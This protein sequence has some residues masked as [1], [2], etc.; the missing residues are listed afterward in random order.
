MYRLTKLWFAFSDLLAWAL[1]AFSL[2]GAIVFPFVGPIYARMAQQSITTFTIIGTCAIWLIVAAGAYAITRRKALG[3]VLVLAP[4]IVSAISGQIAFA[5]AFAVA[6][7]VAFVTPFLLAF[8]QAR[9]AA[10]SKPAA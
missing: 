3:L 2:V 10:T 4:A 5:L 1:L 6:W 8:F 9:L 7:A